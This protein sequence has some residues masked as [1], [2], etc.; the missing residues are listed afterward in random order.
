MTLLTHPTDSEAAPGAPAS[1]QLATRQT[2][3]LC[4]ADSVDD[5]K[6]TFVGRRLHDTPSVLA[7][8]LSAVERT[9]RERG[10]SQR[11]MA[12]IPRRRSTKARPHSS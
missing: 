4:T 5:G 8:Q 3:R 1:A 9:S 12:N 7:D 6:S 11:A 2:L 10:P